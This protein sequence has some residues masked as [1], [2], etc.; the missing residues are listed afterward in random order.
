MKEMIKVFNWS[1]TIPSTT[2]TFKSPTYNEADWKCAVVGA[3][4][5]AAADPVDAIF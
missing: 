3:G 4:I 1:N 2:S 5:G